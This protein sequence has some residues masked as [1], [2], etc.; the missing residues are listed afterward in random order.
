MA[1]RRGNNIEINRIVKYFVISINCG[2]RIYYTRG[3]NTSDI[4]GFVDIRGGG[5]Y[6]VS[7]SFV[8]AL[9]GRIGRGN[10]HNLHNLRLALIVCR[11]VEVALPGL[12]AGFV[13]GVR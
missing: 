1:V 8:Y 12:N 3:T 10:V 9:A 4:V 5:N 11:I 13:T 6:G 7:P 2:R